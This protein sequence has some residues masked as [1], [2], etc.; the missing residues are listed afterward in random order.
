MSQRYAGGIV[1]ANQNANFSGLFSGLNSWLSFPGAAQ[2]AIANSTTPFTIEAWVKSYSAGG[3]IFS[4]E[5][6]SGAINIV[7]SLATS[8]AVEVPSG[9]FPTFGWYNG[10]AWVTAAASTTPLALNTWTH[11]AFVFTGSTSKIYINGVDVTKVSSPTPAITWGVTAAN[12]T[13]WFIGRRWDQTG[14]NI[15]YDGLINNFRFV[16][17]TAVYTANFTPPKNL[18]AITNTVMLTCNGPTFIDGSSYAATIT[19]NNGVIVGTDNPFYTQSTP[20]LG[21]ATPGVWTLSQANQ[22]AGQRSWP[23]YDPFFNLNTAMV[24]GNGTN[25]GTNN[26]FLDSSTNN[27]SVTRNGNTTQG[28]FTPFIRP[29]GYWGNYFGS[30]TGYINAGTNTAFAFGTGDFTLE[31][32]INMSVLPAGTAGN[33]ISA[34]NWTGGLINFTFRVNATTG[35]LYFEALGG[36]AATSN[37]RVAVGQWTHVAC[38]RI[39]GAITFYVDGISSGGATVATNLTSTVPLTI[40]HAF[41]A[42][43]NGYFTGYISNAR[44]VKG[45]ALYTAAFTPS[46]LPLTAV[47]NTSLLTCQ[48]NRFIDNSTN[49]FALTSFGDS[50]TIGFS[51]FYNPTAYLPQINGGGMLFD[52]T[53]DYLVCTNNTTFGTGNFTVECWLYMPVITNTYSSGIIATANYN[54]V[55]RGWSLELN[56]SGNPRFFI[57]T[58]AGVGAV[59]TSSTLL[60]ANQWA[61]LAAVRSGTTV[62]IYLNGASIAS[63]TIATTDDFSGPIYIATIAT[64][65]AVGVRGYSYA[66]WI[67]N[68]RV[69]NGTAVYTANFTPPTAPLTAI[70]N[71]QLLLSGTNASFIDNA[72]N[73]TIE[74][75]NTSISTTQSKYGSGSMS[76]NGTS[77]Y[78]RL[79]SSLPS[80]VQTLGD[81]TVE[82]WVYINSLSTGQNIFYVNG[83]NVSFAAV[84]LDINATSGNLTLLASTTGS[85]HTINSTNTT[86]PLP[87]NA[88]THLAVVRAGPSIIV[89][90]NGSPIITS[91]TIAITTAVM[92]GSFGFSFLG[93]FFNV[94]AGVFQNFLNGYI[95]DF[96]TTN[97][98]RY[99]GVFTPPTST[100]QNQ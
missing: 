67:S 98:A 100:L 77:S 15:Y 30:A 23:M 4:E 88:W 38:V 28:T 52:G 8:N 84:R 45:T 44:I 6:T 62:T 39:S 24:H 97:Y 48:N 43:A 57:F 40:G 11:V 79:N 51:P 19:N 99:L 29:V 63:G 83:N 47:A 35:F 60:P 32:W 31:A 42:G 36:A 61:H 59:V 25:G 93:A 66:G 95:S 86:T 2:Y 41:N 58:S 22:A 89:Y 90:F 10:T 1:T 75:V 14:A 71:T 54:G 74:T 33:I 16:N 53:G 20:A 34:H 69:V 17:G 49:N 76:F 13:N 64:S 55:D 73:L 80:V 91:T 81:F 94:A 68:A 87:I 56:A 78:A 26:T 82:G 18:T 12:G 27:F 46:T 5:F 85:S 7:C 65:F 21:A 96:R 37:I 70:T 3:L 50:R 9:L 92:A 72:T